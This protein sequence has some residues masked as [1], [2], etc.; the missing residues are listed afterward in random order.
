MKTIATT[1]AIA[2]TL[3][4]TCFAAPPAATEKALTL[5]VVGVH[6]GD[7][8]TGVTQANEQ[9]KVRLDAIDAPEL[10]Q[11]FGQAAKKA[12]GDKVFGKTVTVTTK[13]KDRYGRTVGHIL[14][15]KR[16]I[17][18]EMLEEG[19]AWQYREYSKNK[20]LQQ[21]EDE[22]KAGKKGLWKDPN[23]TPPWEWRKTEKDRKAQR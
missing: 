5:K 19:M 9:V 12:L 21:A 2:I 7:T 23:P 15:G 13:K 3:A 4:T 18:L 20:R 10:K 22:A 6:D 17:N 1:V 8:I 11:P 16:D 14:L